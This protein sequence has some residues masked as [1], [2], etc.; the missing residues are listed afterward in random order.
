MCTQD[1]QCASIFFKNETAGNSNTDFSN[2]FNVTMTN[3]FDTSSL[4]KHLLLKL[5]P[6]MGLTY[7]EDFVWR[8]QSNSPT[9]KIWYGEKDGCFLSLVLSESKQKIWGNFECL[10]GYSYAL[11]G[12]HGKDGLVSVKNQD[13]FEVISVPFIDEESDIFAND[14]TYYPDHVSDFV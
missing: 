14:D 7:Y 5:T 6:D 3:L 9:M 12:E 2:Q 1:N 4:P 8:T 11:I 10:D 13:D